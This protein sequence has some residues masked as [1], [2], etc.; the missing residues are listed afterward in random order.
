MLF[1]VTN[2]SRWRKRES[3]ENLLK[4]TNQKF[5]TRFKYIEEQLEKQGKSLEEANI[6]EMEKLWNEAK[7]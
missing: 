1:A 4:K 3:A 6:D 5:I 2:L 7:K